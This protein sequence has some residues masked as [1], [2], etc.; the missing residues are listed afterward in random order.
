MNS[1][2]NLFWYFG[3]LLITNILGCIV[4]GVYVYKKKNKYSVKLIQKIIRIIIWSLYVLFGV[5]LILINEQTTFFIIPSI[6]LTYSYGCLIFRLDRVSRSFYIISVIYIIS[7]VSLQ[8]L[9]ILFRDGLYSQVKVFYG[10]IVCLLY[11]LQSGV[12]AMIINFMYVCI[13]YKSFNHLQDQILNDVELTEVIVEENEECPICLETFSNPNVE[14][15]KMNAIKTECN[16]LFH[17]ECIKKQIE[18]KYECPMCRTYLK[19][20]PCI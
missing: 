17:K 5:S 10:F 8:V 19:V 7:D 11:F 3:S 16:H 1:T 6:L 12:S 15:E 13:Y 9:M 18:N 2:S 20:H 4:V 14:G